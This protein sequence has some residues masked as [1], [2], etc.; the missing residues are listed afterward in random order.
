[1]SIEFFDLLALFLKRDLIII[2]FQRLL[3]KWAFLF[4]RKNCV[5]L[6][7]YL[8]K[9]EVKRKK[10]NVLKRCMDSYSRHAVRNIQFKLATIKLFEIALY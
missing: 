8:S 10:Q 6:A 4:P 3:L 5:F 7:P 9:I 2:S 1:M